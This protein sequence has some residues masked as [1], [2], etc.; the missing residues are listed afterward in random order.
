MNGSTQHGYAQPGAGNTHAQ[1]LPP[2]LKPGIA[3]HHSPRFPASP[4]FAHPFPRGAALPSTGR[5]CEPCIVAILCGLH[6]PPVQ[7]RAASR[8]LP[9]LHRKREGVHDMATRM[10]PLAAG[11]AAVDRNEGAPI[12]LR[13]ALSLHEK[14]SPLIAKL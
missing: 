4:G 12:P 10:A 8:A 5:H 7:G 11:V 9:V 1:A 2:R 3:R 13:L 14:S 6:I